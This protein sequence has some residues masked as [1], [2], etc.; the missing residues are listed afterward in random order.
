[1]TRYGWKSLVAAVLLSACGGSTKP[2]EQKPL[3]SNSGPQECAEAGGQCI[4]GSNPCPNKGPQDCNPDKNPGGAICCLPCP[5]GTEPND[6][7]TA[8][9]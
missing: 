5:S 4:I 8:C 2:E 1:M 9:Q 3:T 7:G 6:A